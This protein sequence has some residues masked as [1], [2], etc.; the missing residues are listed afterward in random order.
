MSAAECFQSV[1]ERD[2]GEALRIL[3]RMSARGCVGLAKEVAAHQDTTV[4]HVFAAWLGAK[5][6]TDHSTHTTMLPSEI[7]PH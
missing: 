6:E 7:I 1:W 5:E 3:S 2:R 4:G